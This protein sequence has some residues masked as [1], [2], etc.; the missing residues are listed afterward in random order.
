MDV[1]CDLEI[2]RAHLAVLPTAEGR[3]N[4][5]DFFERSAATTALR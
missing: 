1:N 4:G 3:S 5:Q 2:Q